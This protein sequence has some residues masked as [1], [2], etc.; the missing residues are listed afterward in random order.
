MAATLPSFEYDGDVDDDVLCPN[1][2]HPSTKINRTLRKHAWRGGRVDKKTGDRLET[3]HFLAAR[4]LSGRSARTR[5]LK[6]C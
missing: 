5:V 1:Q 2:R 6:V 3:S 4:S